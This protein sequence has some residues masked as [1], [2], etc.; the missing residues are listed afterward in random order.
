[1]KGDLLCPSGGMH[2]KCQKQAFW[3]VVRSAQQV[4]R[5]TARIQDFHRNPSCLPS[6]ATMN[7]GGP[8]NP[9]GDAHK[10]PKAGILARR[11]VSAAGAQTY[12]KDSRLSQEPP[13]ARRAGCTTTHESQAGVFSIPEFMPPNRRR[14]FIVREWRL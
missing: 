2:T 9:P 8:V 1:M 14:T 11:T 10:M 13:C 5:P 7:E 6:G 4:R 12:S 3:R